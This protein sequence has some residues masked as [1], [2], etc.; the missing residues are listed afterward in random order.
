LVGDIDP[1]CRDD[2]TDESQG[3]DHGSER[4]APLTTLFSNKLRPDGYPKAW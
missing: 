3:A 4:H 2:A 1:A